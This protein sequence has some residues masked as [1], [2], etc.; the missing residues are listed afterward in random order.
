MVTLTKI[1][2]ADRKGHLNIQG[3]HK[4]T[5]CISISHT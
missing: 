3:I 1:Q 4:N 5:H 2:D